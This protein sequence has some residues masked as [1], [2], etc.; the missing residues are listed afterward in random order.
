MIIPSID[1]SEGRTVQLVGGREPALDA[2]DPVPWA[3][4]FDRVGPVAVIDL[5]R[6]RGTGENTALITSLLPLARC[7]VG[8]GIR[9]LA[10]AR[11]WL[12]RGAAQIILG[13]AAEPE[14]LGQLPRE[15]VIAA[16]DA[17]HGEVMSHGWQRGT[18]RRL[19]DRVRELRDLVGGF[20]VTRIE[21]E[22][23]LAGM[24]LDWARALRE[25]AGP[26]PVTVAGGVADP[27]EIAALD[28]LGLDAQVGMALYTGRFTEAD[29]VA[30]CLRSDR[31]DG[32]WPTVVCD[33]HGRA[34][35]LAYS[36]AGSL[37]AALAEGRGV[38]HSRSRG[39]WIKGESSGAVQELLRVDADCDRDTLRFTVRQHGS[40][41]CHA[42]T[43][44]CFG[45]DH[46]LPALARRLRARAT[47]APAGS[48][49]ARLLQDGDLLAAKLSEEAGELAAAGTAAEV[50]H[51]AADVMYFTLVAMARAGV[52][53]DAVA[54]ELD[55][56]A[57]RLTRRPGH[58]RPDTAGPEEGG[59]P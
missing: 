52:E 22:G 3:R 26:V 1:L 18:G 25:A 16:V 40:G 13:T 19:L 27:G 10:T 14:L 2:G 49:T 36:D 9:D 51:E 42:G 7:R 54:A 53:L 28:A 4:R 8:G 5:D 31:P 44:S 38:Y 17:D 23:R 32:L 48:Y 46:G 41:F 55:R 58:A 33:E 15:R 57:G 56:R 11:R 59:S 35:G 43:W 12:D 50:V 47:G 20:L 39:R 21:R 6:A 45:E 37:A 34:L 29:A 30:A 24:D